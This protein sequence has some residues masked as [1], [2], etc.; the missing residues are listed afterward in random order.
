MSKLGN[1]LIEEIDKNA[2]NPFGKGLM[3][4]LFEKQ[5]TMYYQKPKYPIIP[6]EDLAKGMV[7]L[8][9]E[10]WGIYAFHRDPIGGRFSEEEKLTLIHKAMECAD[11]Y[12]EECRVK[13]IKGYQ[14]PTLIAKN[15][16]AKIFYPRM[17]DTSGYGG[18]SVLFAQFRP[19]NA[20]EVFT[21]CT[22]KATELFSK[23]SLKSILGNVDIKNILLSHELFHMFEER[24]AK[25]I[26][27]E[28]ERKVVFELGPIKNRSKIICLGEIAA[29][30][31]AKN[32][33]QLDYSPYVFDVLL[34][35]VYDKQSA[36]NLFAQIRKYLGVYEEPENIARPTN[37]YD[38]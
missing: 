13:D 11:R 3:G 36:C 33:M 12:A 8:S 5:K 18:N 34:S 37:K 38:E 30:H 15:L 31:F 7:E 32:I 2:Q 26:F 35:Y 1:R 29:M 9:E 16:G 22:D 17:P 27:T 10:Q 28:T 4:K 24:D 21:D 6:V 20:R 19:P 14:S 25:T 23:P